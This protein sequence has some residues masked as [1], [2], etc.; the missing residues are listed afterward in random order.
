[1]LASVADTVV[2]PMWDYLGCG[3]EARINVPSAAGGNWQWRM[4]K[5]G[6]TEHLIRHCRM[7]TEIYGREPEPVPVPVEIEAA[8]AE[9]QA[10][11]ESE[12]P[13][14]LEAAGEADKGKSN[15]PKAEA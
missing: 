13:V 7:L 6:F 15:T 5:G 3:N 14:S 1:M 12:E 11:K 10:A 9:A 8:L 2:I 4:P